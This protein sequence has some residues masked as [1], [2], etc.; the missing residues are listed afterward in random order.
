MVAVAE[1]ST[2]VHEEHHARRHETLIGKYLFS[3][4]HKQIGINYMVTAFIFFIIGGILLMLSFLY[5]APQA[6]WTSY[7]PVSLQGPLG[8]TF[9]CLSII[10]LGASSTLSA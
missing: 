6:G 1:P 5:G 7:P 4:D 9:W 3:T 2:P 10:I 8:Q